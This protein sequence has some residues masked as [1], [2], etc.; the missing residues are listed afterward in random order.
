LNQICKGYKRNKK[1]EKEK[2]KEEIKIEEG[3]RGRFWPSN[4]IGPQPILK[5]R[6]GTLIHSSPR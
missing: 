4:K 3:P 6:T 2:E 5:T 1:A